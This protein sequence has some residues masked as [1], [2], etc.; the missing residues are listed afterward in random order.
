MSELDPGAQPLI[1]DA[2]DARRIR[3]EDRAL[4][5]TFNCG[6]D[7]WHRD[8]SDFLTRKFW[9]PGR[10][11]EAT[12]LAFVPGAESIFGFGCWKHSHTELP[13]RAEPI[14]VIRIPYFGVDVRY[15]GA[16]DAE[17]HSWA[18][19]L[20]RTLEEDAKAHVASSPGM[21]IELFCESRN[22]RGLRFW[23]ARGFQVVGHAYG[24]LLQLLRVP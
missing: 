16:R 10:P 11:Q 1:F 17:G 3:P 12:I 22:E 5:A 19:R 9:Q 23:G 7:E 15:Q 20:Y 4:C 8:V 2:L 24:D 14:P 21:P 18:G 6:D 13:Q